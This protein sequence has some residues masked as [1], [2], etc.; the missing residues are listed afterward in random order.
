MNTNIENSLSLKRAPIGAGIR[1][2]TPMMRR[3]VHRL[4]AG[5]FVELSAL[6]SKQWVVASGGKRH[7]GPAIHLSGVMEKV[8]RLCNTRD[9]EAEMSLLNG[10]LIEDAPTLA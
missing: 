10:G 1:I 6:S 9:R 8:K 7:V 2:N 3:K 5:R 4:I